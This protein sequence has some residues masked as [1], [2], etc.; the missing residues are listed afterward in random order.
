M[1]SFDDVY[2]NLIVLLTAQQQNSHHN[3]PCYNK[4]YVYQHL[5][6]TTSAKLL[7][8]TTSSIEI[9]ANGEQLRSQLAVT[10]AINI[11]II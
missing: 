7:H 10:E 9:T 8:R 5:L 3:K 1:M 6:K 11:P 4:S 2:I